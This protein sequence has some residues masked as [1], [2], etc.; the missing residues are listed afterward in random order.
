[1]GEVRALGEEGVEIVAANAALHLREHALDLVALVLG[2]CDHRGGQALRA[3]RADHT[4]GAS[5]EGLAVVEQRARGEHVIDH[6]A[7]AER[8]G[9]AGIVA[10][11]AP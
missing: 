9:S 2:E 8:A 6:L 4:L 10:R 5:G 7:V 3:G 1:V 11:H